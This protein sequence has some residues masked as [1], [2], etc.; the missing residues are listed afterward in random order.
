MMNKKNIVTKN[1]TMR[2]EALPQNYVL[3][4]GKEQQI[5]F[6]RWLPC[7]AVKYESILQELGLSYKVND[8]GR[9]SFWNP[10]FYAEDTVTLPVFR[11][12]T[13]TK[14]LYICTGQVKVAVPS[15]KTVSEA[16][17]AKKAVMKRLEQVK[18]TTTKVDRAYLEKVLGAK[19]AKVVSI[20]N[21]EIAED[22][23]E[24]IKILPAVKAN[25]E[26]T[27][28]YGIFNTDKLK[29]VSAIKLAVSEQ[30]QGII[31]GEGGQ[32]QQYWEYML[33]KKI[34]LILV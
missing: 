26:Q 12:V 21:V 9:C 24:G 14:D 18:N 15:R 8:D 34:E 19:T 17:K 6:E 28:L 13:N 10:Q 29:Y 27:G 2:K 11:Q 31:E 16:V 22:L 5:R 4:I 23:G 7:V 30:S 33:D 3:Q 32:N 1:T 20:K 25:G